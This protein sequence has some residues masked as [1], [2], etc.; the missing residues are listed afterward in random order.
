MA[1]TS[2]MLLSF[3]SLTSSTHF[4]CHRSGRGLRS[5]RHLHLPTIFNDLDIGLDPDRPPNQPDLE[6]HSSNDDTHQRA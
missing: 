3:A 2:V 4:D 1:L 6:P 5:T